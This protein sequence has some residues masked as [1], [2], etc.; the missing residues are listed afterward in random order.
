MQ[1]VSMGKEH[2]ALNILLGCPQ[3]SPLLEAHTILSDL[4]LLLGRLLFFRTEASPQNTGEQWAPDHHRL[5]DR[6]KDYKF[7][8]STRKHITS[9]HATKELRELAVFL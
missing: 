1:A 2:T 6:R 3:A 7:R 8:K 4:Q 9:K 5:V